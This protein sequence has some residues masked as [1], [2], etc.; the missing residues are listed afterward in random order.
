MC[1]LSY[2][3]REEDTVGQ[4]RLRLSHFLQGPGLDRAIRVSCLEH[5]WI[6]KKLEADRAEECARRPSFM[7]GGLYIS[8]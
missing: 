7:R 4:D 1:C 2:L 5:H 8:N 3:H 6:S